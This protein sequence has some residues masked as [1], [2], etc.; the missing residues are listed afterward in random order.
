M[1]GLYLGM[2]AIDLG[3]FFYYALPRG[4]RVGGE[5]RPGEREDEEGR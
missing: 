3:E 2:S 5:K 1:K 4:E